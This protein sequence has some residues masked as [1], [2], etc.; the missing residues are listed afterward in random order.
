M[1]SILVVE[2]DRC[3]RMGIVSVL[4]K[5]NYDV[6]EA[7]T[8]LEALRQIKTRVFDAVLLDVKLP[9]VSGIEILKEIK[10]STPHTQCVLMSVYVTTEIVI[11]AMRLGACDF[12]IKPFSLDELKLRIRDVFE[13]KKRK[14]TIA[15]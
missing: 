6:S 15:T 11:E 9:G 13:G 1:K 14:F 8:G 10:G 7:N 2:D 5:E 12:L 4:L 3:L